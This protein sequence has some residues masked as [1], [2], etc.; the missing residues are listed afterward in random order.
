MP[1]ASKILVVCV[2]VV[3]LP[4]LW[5]SASVL[6]AR[7][8]WDI[9][10]KLKAEEVA[11]AEKEVDAL[12]NGTDDFRAAFKQEVA[13]P[14]LKLGSPAA[15]TEFNTKFDAGYDARLAF[16][17]AMNLFV[18]QTV[19]DTFQKSINDLNDVQ[20]KAPIPDEIQLEAAVKAFDAAERD[21]AAALKNL[22]AAYDIFLGQKGSGGIPGLAGKGM[23]IDALR[24]TVEH[25]RRIIY[26]QRAV[27]NIML[28][29]GQKNETLIRN[30][31]VETVAEANTLEKAAANGQLDVENRTKE[32]AELTEMKDE[33]LAALLNEWDK[34]REKVDLKQTKNKVLVELAEQEAKRDKAIADLADLTMRFDAVKGKTVLLA[35]KVKELEIRID[36]QRGIKTAVDTAKAS[37]MNS[38]APVM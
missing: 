2:L 38:L 15:N 21:V 33:A 20:K 16:E 6:E 36:A 18:A 10:V 26:A 31:W 4:F 9:K 7:K 5:L 3:A 8:Q 24:Q 19:I 1:L 34:D 29:D 25:F 30:Q 12:I 35:Q 17:A 37:P 28:S 27:F 14:V 11:K 23:S 22:A 32:L 13:D